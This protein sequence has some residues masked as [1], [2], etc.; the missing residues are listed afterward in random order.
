MR[1]LAAQLGANVPHC[2]QN[3]RKSYS[4]FICFLWVHSMIKC[5]LNRPVIYNFGLLNATT[6]TNEFDLFVMA[7]YVILTLNKH[8]NL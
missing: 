2:V 6:T 7:V 4:T 5:G 3:W 1:F 8:G